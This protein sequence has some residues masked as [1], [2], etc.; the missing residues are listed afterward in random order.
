MS[1]PQTRWTIL[2]QL[3]AP[4]TRASALEQL[5]ADYWRPVYAFLRSRGC[6]HE[7][8][9][10]LTQGFF[11]LVV[12][13]G[14]FQRADRQIGRLRSFL[15]GS[16]EN[17]MTNAERTRLA[18]K[19]GGGRPVVSLH[20]PREAEELERLA[21]SSASPAEAFDRAWLD[22]VLLRV[23]HT[24]REQYEAA[25]KGAL[26]NAMLPWLI[27]DSAGSQTE[28]ATSA[29]TSLTN[30][31]VQ[32]HR[33]RIRYRDALRAEIASTM[34]EGSDVASEV[35]YFSAITRGGL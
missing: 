32:L 22:T 16:L 26:F 13:D 17:F 28:A 27:D 5:C 18:Q 34:E 21:A 23:M 1:L 10:D 30:F 35:G 3:A 31:R 12:R 2:A 20:D 7:E 29:G 33:L 15:L 14:L 19:R 8:A 9:E 11:Q 6:N 4:E 25:G 24:L